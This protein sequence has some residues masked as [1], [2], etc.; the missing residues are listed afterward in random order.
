MEPVHSFFSPALA[1]PKK[2]DTQIEKRIEKPFN[3][4]YR[5]KACTFY[6]PGAWKKDRVCDIFRRNV[7]LRTKGVNP[8]Q[9]GSKRVNRSFFHSAAERRLWTIK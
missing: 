9:T 7:S 8:A 4:F 2:M 1:G 5:G 3:A 6:E